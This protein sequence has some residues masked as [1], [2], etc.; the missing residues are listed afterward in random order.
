LAIKYE[1]RGK[2]RMS[3]D[4]L[5]RIAYVVLVL[6]LTGITTGVLGGL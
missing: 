5:R 3:G 1:F 6:V 4:G 2:I